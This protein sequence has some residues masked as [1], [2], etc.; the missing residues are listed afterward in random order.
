M[1]EKKTVEIPH[2]YVS[3]CEAVFDIAFGAG[4]Y[5]NSNQIVCKDRRE[6]FSDVLTWAVEFENGFQNGIEKSDEEYII[7]IFEFKKNK[8]FEKYGRKEGESGGQG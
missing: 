5:A 8:L 7:Q 3:L 1:E 4:W 6:L 2:V